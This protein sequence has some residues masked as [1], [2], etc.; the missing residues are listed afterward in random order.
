M[1]TTK[2][3]IGRPYSVGIVSIHVVMIIDNGFWSLTYKLR[4]EYPQELA[5]HCLKVVYSS[6]TY[7]AIRFM[8]LRDQTYFRGVSNVQ[9][10]F[11]SGARLHRAY[12]N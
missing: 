12:N 9:V 8:F 7:A 1:L 5:H 2:K 3:A 4:I 11:C 10:N 6:K